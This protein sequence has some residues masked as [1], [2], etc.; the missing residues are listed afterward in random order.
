MTGRLFRAVAG[1]GVLFGASATFCAAQT[2]GGQPTMMGE[3]RTERVG[4]PATMVAPP[5]PPD[6]AVTRTAGFAAAYARA[7]S[8]R[9]VVFWN[10]ELTDDLDTDREQ[11]TTLSGTTSSNGETHRADYTR[12]RAGYADMSSSST[13]HV[14]G[15]I[16]STS[17]RIDKG[18]RASVHSEAI[19]F[20]IERGFCDTLAGAGVRL[21]DRT[22]ILRAAGLAANTTNVQEAEARGLLDR[23]ELLIEVVPMTDPRTPSGTSYRI[24]ARELSTGRV[25]ARLSSAGRGTAQKMPFVAGTDG[26]VRATPRE[27]SPSELGRR[28]AIDTMAALSN[29]L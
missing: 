2:R 9:I 10:R 13:E 15:E 23:A 21:V 20:D 22:A 24:I 19:D 6:P 25:L 5:S 4:Q 29:A 8:P 7:R 12:R 14:E 27:A 3:G 18:R 1:A 17:R 26:F 28:V 16:R 11:V